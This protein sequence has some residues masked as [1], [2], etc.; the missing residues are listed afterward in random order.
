M[1]QA[2]E[3]GKESSR[4]EREGRRG[5]RAMMWM[6]G[7]EKV[8]SGGDAGRGWKRTEVSKGDCRDEGMRNEY[9]Q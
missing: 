3:G 9:N 4:V 5:G 7:E 6:E 1:N 2:R 8:E